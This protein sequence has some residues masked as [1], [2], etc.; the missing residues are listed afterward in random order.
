[1]DEIKNALKHESKIP[2]LNN[3]IENRIENSLND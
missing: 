1:M 3:D 2:E